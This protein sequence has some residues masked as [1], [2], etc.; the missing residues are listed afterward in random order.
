MHPSLAQMDPSQLAALQHQQLASMQYQLLLSRGGYPSNLTMP[1]LEH[2][3]QKTYPSIPIP[4]QYLLPKNRDDLLGHLFSKEREIIER[5]RMERERMD[6][7]EK[8]RMERDRQLER[9][10]Q[11]RI[12][13]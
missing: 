1:Q 5:E 7:I 3:W 4:P 6:R 8:E 2:L 12:E 13:R 11:E 10:R 9:E